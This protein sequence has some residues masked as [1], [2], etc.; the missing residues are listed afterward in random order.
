M[1]GEG[2]TGCVLLGV[3]MMLLVLAESISHTGIML[4]SIIGIVLGLFF[5]IDNEVYDSEMIQ[6]LLRNS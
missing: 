3:S 2:L 6:W 4:L 1:N 5:L